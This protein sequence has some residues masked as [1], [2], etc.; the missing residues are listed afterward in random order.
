M[1]VGLGAGLVYLDPFSPD[2]AAERAA[3]EEPE[4]PAYAGDHVLGYAWSEA[5]YNGDAQGVADDLAEL[6]SE[7]IPQVAFETDTA[8]DPAHDFAGLLGGVEGVRQDG[9]YRTDVL[10]SSNVFHHGVLH[11]TDAPG[12]EPV[13]GVEEVRVL[14]NVRPSG[15]LH[16]VVPADSGI[17]TLDDLAGRTVAIGE[18]A[19]PEDLESAAGLVLETAGLADRVAFVDDRDTPLGRGLFEEDVA[20]AYAIMDALPAGEVDTIDSLGYEVRVL[21]IGAGTAEEVAGEVSFYSPVAVDARTYLGQEEEIT[22][23]STWDTLYAPPGLDGELARLLV[24]TMYAGLAEA[25]HGE[26]VRVENALVGIDPDTLHPG[27]RGYYEE[28]GLL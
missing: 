9:P 28:Q 5:W 6:W 22:L 8:R 7:Q 14:G 15:A 20:D 1:A 17:R 27:V 4:A 23:V 12:G 10:M 11:G 24:E 16:F 18:G 13:E 3:S 26:W 2:P 19:H 21:D 25:T